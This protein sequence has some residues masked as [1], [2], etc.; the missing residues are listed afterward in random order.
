MLALLSFAVLA[1]APIPAQAT[2]TIQIMGEAQQ[3]FLPDQAVANVTVTASGKD[4]PTARKAMGEKIL[5]LTKALEEAGVPAAQVSHTR[6]GSEPQYRGQE[7]V[8]FNEREM[9]TLVVTDLDKLD[10]AL[11]VLT[12]AGGTASGPVT[13]RSSQHVKYETQA[14]TDAASVARARAASMLEALGARLGGPISVTDTTGPAGTEVVGYY[15][16]G[17]DGTVSTAFRSR[18][19]SVVSK[20]SVQF[21]IEPR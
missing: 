10:A 18:Q 1:A 20:V 6:A 13:L 2:R 12:R 21:E 15:Q 5:K 14:R 4:E 3:Q 8:G 9:F 11:T 16:A 19:L 17:P 7:V